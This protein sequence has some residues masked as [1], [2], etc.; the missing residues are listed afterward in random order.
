MEKS[1]N[2]FEPHSVQGAAG[3]DGVERR[4]QPSQQAMKRAGKPAWVR[5]G[6][7][8]LVGVGSTVGAGSV[9][10]ILQLL[11]AHIELHWR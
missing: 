10:W 1:V 6:E 11:A 3:W 9:I 8:L 2:E 4:A 5:M 7:Q